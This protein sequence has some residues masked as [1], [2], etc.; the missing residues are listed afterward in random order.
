MYVGLDP[1]TLPGDYLWSAK[2][3]GSLATLS[4]KTTDKNFHVGT[5]YYIYLAAGADNDAL[6]NLHLKQ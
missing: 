4:I 1:E 6:L 3:E 5:Y 2:T